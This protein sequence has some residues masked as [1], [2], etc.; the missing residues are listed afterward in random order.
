MFVATF[1]SKLTW[2]DIVHNELDIKT[3]W[4]YIDQYFQLYG[5]ALLSISSYEKSGRFVS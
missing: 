4:N 3:K 5:S 1:P 2:K